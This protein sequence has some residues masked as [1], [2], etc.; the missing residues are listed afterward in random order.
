MNTFDYLQPIKKIKF[1]DFL[2]QYYQPY[3]DRKNRTT[4]RYRINKIKIFFCDHHLHE[5]N[6]IDL[7]MFLNTQNKYCSNA[8]INRYI[9]RLK[10]I[11]N[12]AIKLQFIFFNPVRIEKYREIPRTRFLSIDEEK[13]LLESC[14]LSK[15]Q[16]LIY[17]VQLAIHTGMRKGEILKTKVRDIC[18]YQNNNIIIV[19]ANNTKSLRQ[20]R[21]PLNIKIY[22]LLRKHL[23]IYE[24]YDDLFNS[25]DIRTTFTNALNDAKI[26]DFRFHDLRH[27]FA[28]RLKEN[29]VG[30]DDIKELLGHANIETTMRYSHIQIDGLQKCVN[31]LT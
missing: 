8:G 30:I 6:M 16:E 27:T 26:K 1:G 23:E 21:I 17:I 3:F 15:N 14:L 11:F 22:G 5:I 9:A 18:Q 7:D 31:T 10:A 25:K 28:T 29:G 12:Y 4:D 19:H 24:N 2:N 13:R 20:R